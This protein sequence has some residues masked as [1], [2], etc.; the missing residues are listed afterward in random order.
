MAQAHASS[1]TGIAPPLRASSTSTVGGRLLR[2]LARRGTAQFGLAVVL[3]VILVAIFAPLIAPHDPLAQDVTRRLVPPLIT[4]RG[5]LAYPLGTDHVGRDILSRLIFGARISLTVGLCSVIV[6]GGIGVVLGLIA[7]YF[8]GRTE[9]VIMRLADIQLAVPFLVLA[10]AVM[11]VLGPSLLNV[12]LVLG[13][14]GWMIYGR[15]VRGEVLSVR[16]KEFI[17]AAKACG[18]G[19]T[20]IIANHIL[21]NVSASIIVIST[22]EVARLIIS[23]ASLSFLGLGVQPPTPTWGGMVADGRDYV[24]TAWWLSVWPGLA[25]LLTVMGVNLLGDWLRDALDPTLR[26]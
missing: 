14:T 5:D 19:H 24:S 7:G 12:I 21:P 4:G 13:I 3:V 23:E 1:Q 25:I 8:R 11:A 15:V 26:R 16:E 20:R 17:E 10:I 18:A 9:A 22:L 2:S 6:Q